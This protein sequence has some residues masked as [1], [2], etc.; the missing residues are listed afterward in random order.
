MEKY[1]GV[2]QNNYLKKII[3]N[4]ED[5]LGIKFVNHGGSL[6]NY[7]AKP[8]NSRYVWKEMQVRLKHPRKNRNR[9]GNTR[10]DLNPYNDS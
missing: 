5:L 9:N 7:Y 2:N 8:H 10:F 1:I 4:K 6:I 3:P